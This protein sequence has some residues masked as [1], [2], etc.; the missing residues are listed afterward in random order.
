MPSPA[1]K[2]SGEM[3]GEGSPGE[4]LV[5]NFFSWCQT[6]IVYRAVGAAMEGRRD[7]PEARIVLGDVVQQMM[8]RPAGAWM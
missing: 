4:T 3:L 2:C 1:W 8:R 5:I 6:M 7:G